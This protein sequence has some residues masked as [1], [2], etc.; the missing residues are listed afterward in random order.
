[1][2]NKKTTKKTNKTNKQKSQT[3]SKVETNK[4]IEKETVKKV[5][6]QEIK[7]TAVK[8]EKIIKARTK[9]ILNASLISL[10]V[11]AICVIS[12]IPLFKETKFG[13]DLQGGFE[14]LYKVSSTDGSE[15]TDEMINSTYKIIS[16]RIDI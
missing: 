7:K 3:T 15:V 4:V 13:L 11:L 12:L 6:K 14:I 9:K 5:E 1:M 10:L 8:D 16:K 2:S